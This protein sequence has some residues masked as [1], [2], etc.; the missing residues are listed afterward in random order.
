MIFKS[1]KCCYRSE[2]LWGYRES[3]NAQLLAQR[4][5]L[6]CHSRNGRCYLHFSKH[7]FIQ[8]AHTDPNYASGLCEALLESRRKVS[9]HP[10]LYQWAKPTLSMGGCAFMN[11]CIQELGNYGETM[12]KPFISYSSL[13]LGSTKTRETRGLHSDTGLASSVFCSQNGEE[14]RSTTTRVIEL[15]GIVTDS[16]MYG[17]AFCSLLEM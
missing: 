10:W 16:L 9:Y 17:K 3:L 14:P 6:R 15:N 4:L 12:A 13:P 5:V 1:R 11:W 2:L 8:H 7:S